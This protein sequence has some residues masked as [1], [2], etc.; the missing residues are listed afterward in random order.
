MGLTASGVEYLAYP[1]ITFMVGMYLGYMYG[2]ACKE[3]EKLNKKN[4]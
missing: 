2:R 4:G 1:V 3:E